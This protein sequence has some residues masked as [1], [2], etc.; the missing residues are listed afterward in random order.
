MTVLMCLVGN[1]SPQQ[2]SDRIDSLI[3]E[4]IDDIDVG[5]PIPGGKTLPRAK[6]FV[7]VAHGHILASMAFR[8]ARQPLKNGMRLLMETAGVA[9]LG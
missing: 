6:N 8:W 4:I 3:R 9:V 1:R 7:C 5:G 2:V